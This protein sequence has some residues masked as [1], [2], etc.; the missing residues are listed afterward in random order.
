MNPMHTD[1]DVK[2][3]ITAIRKVYQAMA[4]LSA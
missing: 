2:D 3:T 1:E 4:G